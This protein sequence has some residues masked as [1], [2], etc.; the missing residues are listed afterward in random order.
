MDRLGGLASAACAM[1]CLTMAFAPALISLVGLGFLADES[2]EWGLFVTAVGF[3]FAAAIFG[4]R[5]HRTWWV[6]AGFGIGILVLMAGRLGEAM[7]L[8]EGGAIV[9]ITGGSLL[10]TT[11]VASAVRTRACREACAS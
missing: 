7:Q 4:Y 2:F 11:H 3:A 9:A 10:L 1:H 8:Y 6:P 5:V